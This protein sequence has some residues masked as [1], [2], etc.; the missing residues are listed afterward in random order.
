METEC[1]R[2]LWDPV[3]S[4]GAPVCLL[5]IGESRS[6]YAPR[7]DATEKQIISCFFIDSLL[8]SPKTQTLRSLEPVA[9][10]PRD[11]RIEAASQQR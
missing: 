5:H 3:L 10:L 4:D 1:H 7:K 8:G 6:G 11:A 2:F 9:R